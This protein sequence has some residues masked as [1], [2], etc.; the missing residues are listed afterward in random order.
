MGGQLFNFFFVIVLVIALIA[1]YMVFF[2]KPEMKPASPSATVTQTAGKDSET[3]VEEAKTEA[4]AE[5]EAEKKVDSTKQEV[6]PKV[7]TAV[8][9]M[10]GS[11]LV[12][13]S[14][15]TVSTKVL[16]GKTVGIYFS[17]HW[18]PPCRAFTP[19]LGKLYRQWRKQKKN[20]QIV[21]VSSDRSQKDMFNYMKETKM[22]WLGI[23]YQSSAHSNID[24]K[25]QVRGIPSL[26]IVDSKGNIITKDGRSDVMRSGANAINQWLKR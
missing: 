16:A 7:S 13:P 23:P 9:Q 19:E 21:F 18:C 15:K 5:P 25:F 1:G 24:K 2:T 12:A 26:I 6:N 20:F 11:K 4:E 3:K 14:G 17:A 10:Y 8:P 22:P